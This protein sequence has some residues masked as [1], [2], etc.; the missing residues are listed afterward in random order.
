[1]PETGIGNL[2][3]SSISIITAPG[4]FQFTNRQCLQFTITRC[5]ESGVHC[6]WVQGTHIANKQKQLQLEIHKAFWV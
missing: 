1:M 6:A 3:R 2:S 5:D 4:I